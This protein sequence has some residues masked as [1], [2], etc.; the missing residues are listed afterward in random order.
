MCC[1]K[2]IGMKLEKDIVLYILR[3]VPDQHPF[4][5]S[6]FLFLI[7]LEYLRRHGEKLTEFYYQLFPE[8][9]FIE[10][11]PQFLE[12]IPEIEKQVEYDEKGNPKRGF[13]RLVKDVEVEL[14][15]DVREVVDAVLARYGQLPDQ[16]LNS[17][18][19]SSPE[20]R[21]FLEGDG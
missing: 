19:V 5:L 20:Y 12:N 16:E 21:K 13:F 7:D 15:P 8:A 4:R 18:V 14:P 2:I 3:E 6:R 1:I 11:F 9:F 17:V 10:G